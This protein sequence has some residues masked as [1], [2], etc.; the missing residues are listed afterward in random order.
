MTKLQRLRAALDAAGK[1]QDDAY[2]VYEACPC[3]RSLKMCDRSSTDWE[4]AL[5]AYRAAGGKDA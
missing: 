2:R 4:R 5:E 1:R 3:R